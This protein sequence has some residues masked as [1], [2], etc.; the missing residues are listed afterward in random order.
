MRESLRTPR[1]PDILLRDRSLI[2]TREE[3]Y[4]PKLLERSRR[5]AAKGDMKQYATPT[6][7]ILLH[8][9]RGRVFRHMYHERLQAVVDGRH[10]QDLRLLPRDVIIGII[11]DVV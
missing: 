9:V 8:S 5:E 11:P 7:R 4:D 3:V 1:S 10:G 2:L 6:R